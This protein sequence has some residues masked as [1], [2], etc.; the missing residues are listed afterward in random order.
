MPGN[1]GYS[2]IMARWLVVAFTGH[3]SRRWHPGSNPVCVQVHLIFRHCQ[4]YLKP[5]DVT[6]SM[7][8][9]Y[10]SSRGFIFF[11]D[12]FAFPFLTPKE[13]WHFVV[14]HFGMVLS[15]ISTSRLLPGTDIASSALKADTQLCPHNS[16][17]KYVLPSNKLIENKIV[18]SLAIRQGD[19]TSSH[20]CL[21]PG[22][23]GYE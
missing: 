18:H 16:K 9:V 1:L 2:S 5:A 23:G 19:S 13:P 12:F 15:L 17:H 11:D 10:E 4:V 8:S 14:L 3:S 20:Y 7:R 22:V 6:D 21:T